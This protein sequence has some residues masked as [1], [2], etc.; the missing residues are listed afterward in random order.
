MKCEDCEYA[1]IEG[2]YVKCENP[3]D[4]ENKEED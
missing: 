4:C 1:L 3:N 2:L